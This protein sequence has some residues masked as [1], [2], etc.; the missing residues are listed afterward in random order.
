MIQQMN[1]NDT[2]MS[3]TLNEGDTIGITFGSSIAFKG[4]IVLVEIGNQLVCH[5][6][7]KLSPLETKGD[8]SFSFDI[9]PNFIGTLTTIEMK[10][11]Q[12]RRLISFALSWL[13]P[14]YNND[15]ILKKLIRFLIVL[16]S[17]FEIK[18]LKQ[19]PT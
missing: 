19:K 8:K 5:R 2:S 16:L 4:Q 7:I 12:Q 13:S 3:P 11:I 18:T 1:V 15:S 9:S 14:F 17:P 10:N 6:V